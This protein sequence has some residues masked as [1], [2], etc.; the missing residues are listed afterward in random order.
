VPAWYIKED[1]YLYFISVL[2]RERKI[3]VVHIIYHIPLTDK[4]NIF[5]S[6]KY[7]INNKNSTSECKTCLSRPNG[8]Q[9]RVSFHWHPFVQNTRR[10]LQ[11]GAWFTREE[12]HLKACGLFLLLTQHHWA[13]KPKG[14]LK[15]QH[16]CIALN[17]F[18]I[19]MHISDSHI[20]VLERNNDIPSSLISSSS[21][22]TL[23]T[24]I[25]LSIHILRAYLFIYLFIYLYIYIYLPVD[26]IF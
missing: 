26:L 7:R 2:S 21:I 24:Y 18:C 11:E 23:A 16:A 6:K 8:S 3:S 15:A 13:R 9:V 19:P 1:L 17:L 22:L 10:W 20:S 25:Y 12:I 4:I 5:S 14:H